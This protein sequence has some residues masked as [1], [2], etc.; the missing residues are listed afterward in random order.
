MFYVKDKTQRRE[1]W[2]RSMGFQAAKNA[3]QLFVSPLGAVFGV[4]L[5]KSVRGT[6]VGYNV[7]EITL[8]AAMEMT[9]AAYNSK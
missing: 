8:T 7:A 4:L 3:C 2:L 9:V 6:L 1:Y 5:T